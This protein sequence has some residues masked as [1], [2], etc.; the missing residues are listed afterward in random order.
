MTYL[1]VCL[2]AAVLDELFTVLRI[3]TFVSDGFLCLFFISFDYTSIPPKRLK[4]VSQMDLLYWL[5][6]SVS[7]RLWTW[8]SRKLLSNVDL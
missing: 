5:A 6:A 4:K 2:F 3:D 8:P 7:Q 1:T